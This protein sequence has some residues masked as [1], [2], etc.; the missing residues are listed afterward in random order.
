MSIEIRLS[1]LPTDDLS[2]A[3]ERRIA[4][5]AIEEG[6][7]I[8]WTIDLGLDPV[9]ESLTDEAAFQ[10]RAIALTTFV[11]KMSPISTGKCL[12]VVLASSD[13]YRKVHVR[14]E[15]EVDFEEV[16][17]PFRSH[18]KAMTLFS[19]Y[20]H[21]LASYLPEDVPV[22]VRIDARKASN[23]ADVAILL[24]KERFRYFQIEVI[25]WVL[26]S[27]AIGCV[28]PEDAYCHIKTRRGLEDI[29]TWLGEKNESFRLVPEN[30]LNEEWDGLNTLIVLSSATSA[31][32]RRKIRGFA[33]TGGQIVAFGGAIGI[34]GE[35]VIEKRIGAEGFEPPT[36]CSQSS[37]A[38]QAA[39][40]SD[41]AKNHTHDDSFQS[42][43]T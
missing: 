2:W 6:K 43:V 23:L 32:G 5:E 7:T 11:K 28:I 30:L 4:L 36:Y 26:Q 8:L 35:T 18:L 17:E 31:F 22:I 16:E 14:D 27:G 42:T 3:I 34:E 29:F 19:D 38:S 39:L 41:F 24:S 33:A 9:V 21:R 20:L 10:Q 13:L 15:W 1:A 25:G 12:G 37:R 40:C